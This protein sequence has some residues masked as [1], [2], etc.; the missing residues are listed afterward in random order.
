[1]VARSN[2]VCMCLMC[3]TARIKGWSQS[4]IGRHSDSVVPSVK[5]TAIKLCGACF[6][7]LGKGLP[8]QCTK[9]SRYE[10]LK[11]MSQGKTS[12]QLAASLLSEKVHNSSSGEVI[13]STFTGHPL[14]VEV[15]PSTSSLRYP[16]TRLDVNDLS[17]IQTHLN[18]SSNATLK[19]ASVV[20]TT[21]GSRKSI[22]ANA[23]AKLIKLN[24]S[25]DSFLTFLA[26]HFLMMANS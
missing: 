23:K 15:S 5:N 13:L 21:S 26:R 20:R 10:N 3:E 19:L 8:H 25:L 4:K 17:K 16:L 11:E 7:T 14:K 22:A 18:L 1:M 9:T 6:T 2:S 24:H 12:E